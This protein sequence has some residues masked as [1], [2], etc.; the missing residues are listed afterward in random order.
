M[1]ENKVINDL[2]NKRKNALIKRIEDERQKEEDRYQSYINFAKDNHDLVEKYIITNLCEQYMK[3]EIDLETVPDYSCEFSVNIPITSSYIYVENNRKDYVERY[4]KENP[5]TNN[6]FVYIKSET[7]NTY[8]P[9]IFP[10]EKYVPY[11]FELGRPRFD[12]DHINIIINSKYFKSFMLKSY[13]HKLNDDY[14]NIKDILNTNARVCIDRINTRKEFE[15]KC[16]ETADSLIIEAWK[17]ILKQ[18]D[19]DPERVFYS[20][21]FSYIPD[22]DDAIND[23]TIDK[24]D[25]DEINNYKSIIPHD[26]HIAFTL[27]KMDA[28]EE[29]KV[30]CYQPILDKY[31]KEMLAKFSLVEN[32]MNLIVSITRDRLEE[33]ILNSHKEQI[34]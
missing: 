6:I 29:V 32:N 8:I 9:A 4:K 16:K 10:Y 3:N 7:G 18:Y 34:K 19:D 26:T 27:P 15:A 30:I 33:L 28:D 2:L 20:T 5:T 13:F 17:K 1:D 11:G 31:I 21:S 22:T 12:D 23:I 14:N 25:T 24:Q